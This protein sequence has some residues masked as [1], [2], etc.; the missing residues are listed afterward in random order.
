MIGDQRFRGAFCLQYAP[1]KRQSTIILHGSISQ[2]TIL[3]ITVIAI[4]TTITFIVSVT[5]RE[6]FIAIHFIGHSSK[7]FFRKESWP[8]SI[9]FQ[10]TPL[11]SLD[12]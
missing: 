2:K 11:Y 4:V 5:D 10:E 6:I 3:D 9:S 12:F 7:F 1:L 8:K